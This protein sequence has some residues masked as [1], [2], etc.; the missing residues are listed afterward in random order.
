MY[1]N[2]SDF[3]LRPFGW[4]NKKKFKKSIKKFSTSY[5]VRNIH[6]FPIVQIPY[7]DSN[8]PSHVY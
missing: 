7:L 1:K 6:P 3:F 2:L 5:L 8:T 4:N